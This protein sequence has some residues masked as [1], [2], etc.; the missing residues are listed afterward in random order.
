MASPQPLTRILFPQTSDCTENM[1]VSSEEA[2]VN[3]HDRVVAFV[4]IGHTPH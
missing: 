3:K 2:L 1:H 4:D